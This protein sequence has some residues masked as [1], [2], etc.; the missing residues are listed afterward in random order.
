MKNN[1]WQR[2]K[3]NPILRENRGIGNTGGNEALVTH[4]CHTVLFLCFNQNPKTFCTFSSLI[5]Y[6]SII[7]VFLEWKLPKVKTL[8][9]GADRMFRYRKYGHQFQF[10]QKKF[11]LKALK[12]KNYINMF[13]FFTSF[14]LEFTQVTNR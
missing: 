10:F 2:C 14:Q 6:I 11:T 8:V 4:T 7:S 9:D 1:L 12:S 3:S 5:S 13:G